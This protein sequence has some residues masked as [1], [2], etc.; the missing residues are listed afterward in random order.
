MRG[1]RGGAELQLLHRTESAVARS[2]DS[3]HTTHPSHLSPHPTPH[4]HRAW[5]VHLSTLWMRLLRDDVCEE[6]EVR[7]G[8]VCLLVSCGVGCVAAV[9]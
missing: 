8:K 2:R 4:R 7:V 9:Q 5:C 3:D 1:W 6:L